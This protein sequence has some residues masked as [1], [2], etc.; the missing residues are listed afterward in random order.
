FHAGSERLERAGGV[1][2]WGNDPAKALSSGWPDTEA[3]PLRVL[4]ER[5]HVSGIQRRPSKLHSE[6]SGNHDRRVRRAR[7]DDR[8]RYRGRLLVDLPRLRPRL[9][10]QI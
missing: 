6:P 4:L 3:R 2:A 5:V 10:G 1:P 9:Q 8:A 7:W